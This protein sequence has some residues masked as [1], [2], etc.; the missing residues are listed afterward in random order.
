M[1][2]CL[3]ERAVLCY[4][5][6]PRR[7]GNCKFGY[8]KCLYLVFVKEWEPFI[9]VVFLLF[10]SIVRLLQTAYFYI[11]LCCNVFSTR[12]FSQLMCPWSQRSECPARGLVAFTYR[13]L[14][15][16]LVPVLAECENWTYLTCTGGTQVA[17]VLIFFKQLRSV[18]GLH[19]K[20]ATADKI[21]KRIS[22]RHSLKKQ[23]FIC[24]W[25]EKLLV[26]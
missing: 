2:T 23:R 8:R 18:H 1:Q 13:L 25:S 11:S 3:Q 20:N 12:H 16:S 15:C 14:G 5:K 17:Y 10:S 24:S 4:L 7:L 9:C 6:G 26:L 19:V 22:T 21:L